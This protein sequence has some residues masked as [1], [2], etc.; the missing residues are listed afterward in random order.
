MTFSAG[1][2]HGLRSRGSTFEPLLGVQIH[3][4]GLRDLFQQILNHDSV[5]IPDVARSQFDVKVTLYDVYV[6][7]AL[8][9]SQEHSLVDL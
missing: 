5:V 8:R 1:K 7:L 3:L 2:N 4:L 6:Q 9:R